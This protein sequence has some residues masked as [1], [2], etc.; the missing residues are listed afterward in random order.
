MKCSFDR[1]LRR[2][3]SG[4]LKLAKLHAILCCR[5]LWPLDI[6]SG[7]RGH[8]V[9]SREVAFENVPI[10][11]GSEGDHSCGVFRKSIGHL[12][13]KPKIGRRGYG[14]ALRPIYPLLERVSCNYGLPG[15][16]A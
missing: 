10:W 9:W 6:L 8:F 1:A 2:G 4:G 7:T 3:S 13:D 16:G 14:L 5:A 12:V 11:C 15:G